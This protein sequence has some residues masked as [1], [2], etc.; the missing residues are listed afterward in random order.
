M[1]PL[2]PRA[3]AVLD[4]PDQLEALVELSFRQP[5]LIIKHSP[6]CGTSFQALDDLE[7]NRDLLAGLDVHLIDVLQQRAL[8]QAIASRFRVRHE[9]PQVLLL[10]NGR[11]CWNASHFRVTAEAVRRASANAASQTV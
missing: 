4:R 10:L 8:S 6:A 9:S 11:V 3:F 7:E 5:V 1:Q 2:S